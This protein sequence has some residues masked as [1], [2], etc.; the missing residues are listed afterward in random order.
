M[1]T[2]GTDLAILNRHQMT[3]T[4]SELSPLFKIRYHTIGWT[5]ALPVIKRAKGPLHDGSSEESGFEPGAFRIRGRHL[6]TRQQ[7]PPDFV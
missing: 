2:F 1:G 6:T 7:R 4:T 5:L 3:R